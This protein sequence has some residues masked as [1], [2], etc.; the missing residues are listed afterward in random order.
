MNIDIISLYPIFWENII[1]NYSIFKKSIKNNI[2]KIYIHYL[3]NYGIGKNKKIDDY[4]YGGGY[5][6]VL[7]IEPIYNCIKKIKKKKKIK[8]IIYLTPNSKLFNQ[9][10]ANKLSKEKNL[11]F[12]CGHYKGIDQRIRDNIITKEYSIGNYIISNGEIST[13]IVIDSIIRL[14]PGVIK[15]INS[16]ITDS[17]YKDNNNKYEYPLY[18]RPYNFNNM[19]VPKILLSGNHKKIINWR[20]NKIKKKYFLYKDKGTK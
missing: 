16:I 5:G 10:I 17:L 6:M 11:V 7:K 20:K 8:K 19:K 9:K 12:I 14:I 3:K 13:L 18:T 1:I 15:N 4:Q 2:L